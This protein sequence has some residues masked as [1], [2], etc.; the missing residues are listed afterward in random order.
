M[1]SKMMEWMLKKDF[2]AYIPKKASQKNNYSSEGR[3]LKFCNKCKMV[4]EMGITGTILKYDHMPTYGLKRK[5]CLKC[6]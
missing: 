6:S 3:K 4:W 2:K 1:K 5:D